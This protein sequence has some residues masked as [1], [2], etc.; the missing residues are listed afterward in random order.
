MYQMENVKWKIK[1][2]VSSDK[3]GLIHIFSEGYLVF[4]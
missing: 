4:I 1:D 3:Y 2:L